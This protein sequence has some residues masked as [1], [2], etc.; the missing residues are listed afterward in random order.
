MKINY[1]YNIIKYNIIYRVQEYTFCTAS[2]IVSFV[3]ELANRQSPKS[4]GQ[5]IRP[6]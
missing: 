5:E 2:G 3:F 4:R 1:N 6:D